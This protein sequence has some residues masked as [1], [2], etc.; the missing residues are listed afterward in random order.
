MTPVDDNEAVQIGP[1][2]D[3]LFVYH[4]QQLS[5]MLDGE[6]S[7][8]EA[9]FML[10]RLQHDTVLASCWERWQV[11]G[12]VLRGQR[13][14][15][16]PADFAQRVAQSLAGGADAT[17][18]Q[19]HGRGARLRMLR[20]GG[21][22]AVAASV[23]L[24]A[25]FAG[26]QLP[27]P[28]EAPGSAAPAPLVAE[29]AAPAPASPAPQPATP[30]LGEGP[31]DAGAIVASNLPDAPD[32]APGTTTALAASAL[33]LAE[34]PRRSAE[35]RTRSQAPAVAT[36]RAPV[37]VRSEVPVLVADASATAPATVVVAA[38][39]DSAA[40]AQGPSDPFAMPP[41][42]SRPWPR[43]LLPAVSG[44]TVAGG[45][46]APREPVFEPFL[47]G[48]GPVLPWPPPVEAAE[49]PDAPAAEAHQP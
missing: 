14:D 16:L 5:A 40:T 31:A 38:G 19:G 28:G 1:D 44:Y 25:V 21:G 37:P 13:N 15:L 4:R 24:L 17:L 3:K 48:A 30:T 10:R 9:R 35:R 26:R 27:V 11:C 20:W 46:L 39:D 45:G 12:D 43:S 36:R 6:L 32:Q 29:A 33:A 2:P 49:A 8:D 18:A 42:V 23:A 7:P 22:A 41:A 34:A 47:P